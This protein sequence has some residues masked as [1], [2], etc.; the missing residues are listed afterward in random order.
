MVRVWATVVCV[1]AVGGMV[2][3][4]VTG[5]RTVLR[6]LIYMA[7][8]AYVVV[9][10]AGPAVVPAHKWLTVAALLFCWLGDVLGPGNFLLGVVMFLVAHLAL[11]PT[12]VVKGI[13]PRGLAAGCLAAL[14]FGVAVVAWVG[15]HVPDE[16]QPLI[17]GYSAVISLMLGVALGTW[18]CGSR[19]MI[20]VAAVA[21]YVSDLCLAQTAFLGR[22]IAFTLIGYPLY[23]GACLLFAWSVSEARPYGT[24][25]SSGS[26][27]G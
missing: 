7:S 4:W 16:Q 18:R 11:V 6:G 2:T 26:K 8:T 25:K 21:F 12:F 10:I 23:Y 9:A 20:P 5:D 13:Y 3:E 1:A 19:W 22:G 14:V 15:P 27:A 24:A 17:Y